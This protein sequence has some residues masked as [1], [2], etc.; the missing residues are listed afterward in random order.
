[1]YYQLFFSLIIFAAPLAAMVGGQIEKLEALKQ[2]VLHYPSAE[3]QDFKN[4]LLIEFIVFSQPYSNLT[5]HL[6]IEWLLKHGANRNQI[7]GREPWESLLQYL[8]EHQKID[9]IKLFLQYK[10]TDLTLRDSKGNTPLHMAKNLDIVQLLLTKGADPNAQN[11]SG[12]TP[13]HKAI[14]YINDDIV[15]LL[16]SHGADP[17]QSNA[18]GNAFDATI[19]MLVDVDKSVE[20]Q[21]EIG[22][23]PEY[24]QRLINILQL[25]LNRVKNSSKYLMLS[26]KRPESSFA[27][28][29]E[30]QKAGMAQIFQNRIL[31]ELIGEETY[32]KVIYYIKESKLPPA[33]EPLT[34]IAVAQCQPITV[35]P[36]SISRWAPGKPIKVLPKPLPSTSGEAPSS[37][38]S[39]GGYDP[40]PLVVPL[41]APRAVGQQFNKQ[42]LV[43]VG[44]A[45]AAGG[46]GIYKYLSTSVPTI[47]DKDELNEQLI[48]ALTNKQYD[49]AYRLAKHNPQALSANKQQAKENLK[50]LINQAELELI[51]EPYTRWDTL[52]RPVAATQLRYLADLLGLIES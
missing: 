36:G 26:L 48:T 23:W 19:G 5:K 50:D 27:G 7:L 12:D 25:L 45:L 40:V 44:A 43:A 52:T 9:L 35:T 34:E 20:L 8:V 10:N 31:A 51:N 13:L 15:K 24:R 18:E 29:G 33:E 21:R 46:Y 22:D 4:K 32:K 39:A 14:N 47:N 42:L 37:P 41:V 49:Y 6:F 38:P 3:R 28:L 16:L 17:F 11:F 30:R 1:M 2:Q